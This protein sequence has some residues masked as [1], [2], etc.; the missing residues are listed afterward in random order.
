MNTNT[1]KSGDNEILITVSGNNLESTT[2]K[3][4]IYKYFKPTVSS[5][6][7]VEKFEYTGD[8]QVFTAP[9]TTQYKLEVWGARGGGHHQ[10]SEM[11]YPGLGGYSTGTVRLKAGEKLYI[12]VGEEGPWTGN[13]YG[14]SDTA[15]NGGGSG[16]KLSSGAKNPTG[17]GGGAT[18]IR[19]VPGSWDDTNSLLS[20]II[21]G[22]GGGLEGTRYSSSYGE[23]GT[24]TTGWAFGYGFSANN[25]NKQYVDQTWGCAGGGGGWYG[26]K[27]PAGNKW[28][29][30]GGGSGFVWTEESL[31]N[32]PEGYIPSSKYYL[33]NTETIAGNKSM[34]THD[35]T[36]T[37]TGNNTNGYAKISYYSTEGLDTLLSITTDKG[38]WQE[39]FE[40]GTYEYYINLNT[41]DTEITFNA[42]TELNEALITGL[43]T[44]EVPAGITEFQIIMTNLNGQIDIYTITVSRPA[45]P[46]ALLNGFKVN[47][48]LYENFDKN[49]FDYE[50]E[51]PTE[52]EKINLELIKEYPGQIIPE[53]TIYDF[54]ENEKTI[55]I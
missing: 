19:L 8:Y 48:I 45:N 23:S 52:I 53:N 7:I 2:Y 25:E 22:D 27:G 9:Y 40:L 1:L 41:E 47:G 16:Q 24:Q 14:I 4:N 30:G 3:F 15:W 12:Y 39:E 43:G 13:K 5:D 10:D 33:S 20:R 36:T 55:H 37:M 50:I 51:L 38:Q 11:G 34:P 49:T 21:V 17:A 6:P 44:F 42:T 29:S 35:G 31:S 54:T 32:V 18:D 28:E 26:G 46:S